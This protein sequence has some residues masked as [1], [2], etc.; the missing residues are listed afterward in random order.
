HN[1]TVTFSK[2]IPYPADSS[3]VYIGHIGD[4]VKLLLI[5]HTNPACGGFGDLDIFGRPVTTTASAAPPN[6]TGGW[7]QPGDASNTP[8]ELKTSGPGLSTLDGT[9]R[10]TGAHSGLSG[11]FHG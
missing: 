2:T 10:G 4:A 3:V 6:L 1:G 9:W 5:H 11:S 7:V 8:W